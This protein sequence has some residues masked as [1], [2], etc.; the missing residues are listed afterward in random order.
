MGRGKH[1]NGVREKQGQKLFAVNLAEA[2]FAE[3]PF[4]RR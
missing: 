4:A 3:P 1:Q 2:R